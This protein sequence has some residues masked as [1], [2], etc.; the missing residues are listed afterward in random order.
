MNYIDSFVAVVKANYQWL[1]GGLGASLIAGFLFNKQRA[2]QKQTVKDKSV[3]IQAGRDVRAE[4]THIE[5]ND[6]H[7]R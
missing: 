5:K 7:K 3:G 4:V 1:F 2:S 6:V